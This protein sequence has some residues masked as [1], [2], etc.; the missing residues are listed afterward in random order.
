[1]RSLTLFNRANIIY[2]NFCVKKI[3]YIMHNAQDY[4]VLY[5]DALNIP[6]GAW[7]KENRLMTMPLDALRTTSIFRFSTYEHNLNLLNQSKQEWSKLFVR[8]IRNNLNQV[9]HTFVYNLVEVISSWSEQKLRSILNW[10]K[11]IGW[12]RHFT[13]T[14]GLGNT[15]RVVFSFLFLLSSSC[16]PYVASFSGL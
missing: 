6:K 10:W 8:F 14:G 3:K 9:V 16:V 11:A 7:F 15:Y 5:N 13:K 2:D 12:L 4:S 1:L